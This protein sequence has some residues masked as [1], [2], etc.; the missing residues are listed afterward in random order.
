MKKSS[1]LHTFI[2]KHKINQRLLAKRIGMPEGTFKN[3]LNPK[4]EMYAFT[5]DEEAKVREA[6]REVG[7]ELV[8][9]NY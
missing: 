2:K 7:N 5:E 6:I 8:K 1:K 9:G 3:K 4:Y